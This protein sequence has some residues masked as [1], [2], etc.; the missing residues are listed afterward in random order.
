MSRSILGEAETKKEMHEKP[1]L[2]G[3]I[4]HYRR[5]GQEKGWS[6]VLLCVSLL[7]L[8]VLLLMFILFPVLNFSVFPV[9]SGIEFLI[10]LLHQCLYNIQ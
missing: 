1:Q 9:F 2:I 5:R 3:I 6:Q 8:F 10:N 4:Q 7:L